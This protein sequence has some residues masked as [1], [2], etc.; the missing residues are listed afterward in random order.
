[1]Q[2]MKK[3]I[4]KY[5]KLFGLGV[6]FLMAEAFCDLL[7]PAIMAKIVDVGV[8]RRNLHYVI[9]MGGVM[10][11][12]T[13]LGAL[14]AVSRN[15]ISN[16][17][18]QRFGAELRF[19][20]FKKIQT[21]SFDNLNKF[22]TGSLVTRLTNDVTQVQNFVN[23][24]MRIFVKAPLV[25]IGSI[26]MA[27]LLDP[28]LAIILIAVVPVI[29]VLMFI[30]VRIGYPFFRK[31]QRKL[32][33]LNTVM[34]EYLNGVRVVKAFNRFDY[35][36]E[37]F[38]GA[39]QEL[40]S[41]S[42]TAMRVM[43]IF[44][45]TITLTVNI[46][47]VGVLWLGGIRVNGGQMH[48]GQVIAFVNYMTQILASLMTISFV[49]NMFVRAR[50]STERIAEVMTQE[51]SMAEVVKPEKFTQSNGR[52]DFTDVVFSYTGRPEEAVLKGITFKCEPG[53]TI[54]IIGST[55]SGKST[56]VSLIPRFYDAVSGVV[57]VDGVDVKDVGP[58]EL[59][60]KIAI[61]PQK[62]VLFS[63]TIMD[64]IRWG[65]ADGD[66]H[67]VEEVAQVAQA[68][69]FISGFPEQY[70][71]YL[72]QGGVNLSGGQ[73][74]RISIAR[75]LIKKPEILI[76][77]DSTSAVDMAT[78]AK[79]RKEMREYAK[80]MT[81]L[82]ITQRIVSAMGSDRIIVLDNGEIVGMGTHQQLMQS[83]LVYQ[84]IYR[85]QIGKED[86]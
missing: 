20:L 85:S 16:N 7:Q 47:I 56:L 44:T 38:G 40:A 30:S 58:L 79:I 32:D 55:G 83:S 53:E 13:A 86:I 62:T 49:F 23:G 41:A 78:E 1:M 77:D 11:G 67:E 24:L 45:P 68:H 75:A 15:I 31:V 35:E 70:R 84:D 34:R 10:L 9:T 66:I 65:K 14:A 2:F 43:A 5:W 12:V 60:K 21:F 64:N 22:E 48:V 61:V 54:A 37:R 74:Q 63:G 36:I 3:Y 33:G 76:L 8:A 29:A 81:C 46:G 42:T 80:G 69:S 6:S 39:N 19:D 82:I 57:K 52:I 71:T 28:H 18:S 50:A 4:N 73:K 59:R 25:C 26:I 17:V 27:T 72:G 51:N